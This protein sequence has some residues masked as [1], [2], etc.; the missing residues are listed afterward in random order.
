VQL[1]RTSLGIE[2]ADAALLVTLLADGRRRAERERWTLSDDQRRLLDHLDAL[3]RAHRARTSD[4]IGPDRTL[5][6]GPPANLPTMTTTE[7][8]TILGCTERNVIR[9][10]GRNVIGA[11]MVRGRWHVDPLD[12]HTYK[13]HCR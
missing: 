11:R 9:L 7:A 10:V 12:V 3:A 5:P 8:A 13:E 4:P 1:V 6:D 2:A